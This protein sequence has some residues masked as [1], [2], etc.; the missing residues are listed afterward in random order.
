MGRPLDVRT[1]IAGDRQYPSAVDGVRWRT[2]C[3]AMQFKGFHEILCLPKLRCFPVA[4]SF[5]LAVTPRPVD[6][7]T[8][9]RSE[10][11]KTNPYE[12]L[13]TR[14][15]CEDLHAT[16]ARLMPLSQPV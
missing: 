13:H 16:L 4:V 9:Q 1:W 11:H 2:L 10:I 5:D 8:L 12:K 7:R 3:F 15:K 14:R 6:Q